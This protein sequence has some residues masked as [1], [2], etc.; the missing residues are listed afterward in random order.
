V[1]H[2]HLPLYG[3]GAVEEWACT[4]ALGVAAATGLFRIVSDAHYVTDVLFGAGIGWFYGYVMPRF[5]HYKHGRLAPATKPRAFD[6][7]PV[8]APTDGGAFV[9]LS[10]PLPI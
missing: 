8:F 5:L 3:G 6:W 1:H 7:T 9:G 4:W 2:Q 10:A